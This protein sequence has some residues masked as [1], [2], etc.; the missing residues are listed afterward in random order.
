MHER[1]ENLYIHCIIKSQLSLQ[2]LLPHLWLTMFCFCQLFWCQWVNSASWMASISC[3]CCCMHTWSCSWTFLFLFSFL[4]FLIFSSCEIETCIST[5]FLIWSWVMTMDF[6]L[7]YAW[8]LKS[9]CLYDVTSC[10]RASFS[11]NR[12]AMFIDCLFSLS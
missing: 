7:Y 4:N 11:L 9:I 5:S 6:S 8:F 12:V 2:H 10:F 1:Y 3:K